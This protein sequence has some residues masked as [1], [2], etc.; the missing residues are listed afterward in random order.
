MEKL[1]I[2]CGPTATGKTALGIYLAKKFNGEIVSADSRQVYRGMDI[3]TG[4][5][6]KSGKWVARG[7]GGHWQ[8]KGVSLWLIDVVN[9]EERFTTADYLELAGK[10][11]KTI[12]GRGKLP[13]IVGGTGL[14]IRSL[15]D[16]IETLGIL[17]DWELRWRLKALPVQGLFAMLAQLDPERV[18]TM[19]A[20]DRK[21][22]RRLI[23]AIEITQAD[24]DSRRDFK[25]SYKRETID[26]LL[27]GLRAPMESLYQRIDR[28]VEER[29]KQRIKQEIE[30][31]LEKGY[32][33]ESS[34]MGETLGYQE[35]RLF[36][37]G[38]KTEKEVI[39]R[40]QF[41]EHGYARR[42]MTWFKKDKRINWLD[43]TKF[44]WKKAV[45]KL[46]R[47]WYSEKNAKKD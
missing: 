47:E 18:A 44:G 12:R 37:G 27:I 32:T 3:G 19:N 1:L 34:A 15:I 23:R 8:V 36:F 10:T 2:I 20:S 4:K 46:T 17:P 14:Y 39:Q 42:Q 24:A 13:I 5:D 6:I 22:P 35:W 31:L 45:V 43:I 7:K 16:G 30:K 40:W 29:V 38:E 41:N 28:R 26:S 11:I 21:N 9:P 33:W 25:L